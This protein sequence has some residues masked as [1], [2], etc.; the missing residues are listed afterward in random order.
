[1]GTTLVCFRCGGKEKINIRTVLTPLDPGWFF[2]IG[3][4][5]LPVDPIQDALCDFFVVRPYDTCPR[6]YGYGYITDFAREDRIDSIVPYV[7]WLH[8]RIAYL[9]EEVILLREAIIGDRSL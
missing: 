5:L 4:H 3:A 7:N 8:S 2:M 6:C 9:E 1:M